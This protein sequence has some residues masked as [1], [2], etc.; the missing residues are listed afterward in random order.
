MTDGAQLTAEE[1]RRRLRLGRLRLWRLR[2]D[3]W[4]RLEESGRLEQ[5]ELEGQPVYVDEVVGLL[6]VR[7]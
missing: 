5:I 2:Y 4:R 3:E 1:I 7:D 6:F